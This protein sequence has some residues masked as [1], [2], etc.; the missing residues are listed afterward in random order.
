MGTDILDHFEDAGRSKHSIYPDTPVI[1]IIAHLFELF[2]NEGML[3]PAMHYRWNF[4]DVN[5][6]FVRD[7]FRDALTQ[8]A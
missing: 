2:G 7:L 4:D 1:R 3:R 6:A 8:R 5:L